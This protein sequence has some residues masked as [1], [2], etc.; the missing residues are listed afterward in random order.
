MS[1]SGRPTVRSLARMSSANASAASKCV[2]CLEKMTSAFA[3]ANSRPAGDAPAWKMTGCPWAE[4][5]RVGV[6]ETWK[7]SLSRATVG[8]NN[9]LVL[10]V[11]EPG[12]V[13]SIGLRKLGTALLKG[14]D[15]LAVYEVIDAAGLQTRDSDSTGASLHVVLE[16]EFADAMSGRLP[17]G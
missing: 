17:L 11:E 10:A 15:R 2:P 9:Y 6:I 16:Q 13:M 3:A 4:R 8:N 14:L 12:E 1:S 5:G 7:C